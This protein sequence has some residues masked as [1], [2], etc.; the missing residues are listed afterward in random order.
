[1]ELLHIP[2]AWPLYTNTF[3][4]FSGDGRAAVVDP[5]PT[6][7]VYEKALAEHGARLTDICSP[8]AITTMSLRSRR[9]AAAPGPRSAWTPPTP[10]GT[11]LYPLTPDLIDEP[12]PAADGMVEAAGLSFRLWHTP[13][14]T[15]G[16]VC[17][18]TDGCLFCGDTLFAGSCGRMDLPGGSVA[19]MQK[20]LAFIAALPLRTRQRF[21]PGTSAFPPLARSAAKTLPD[22]GSLVKMFYLKLQGGAQC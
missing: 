5:A 1:M 9:C 13:G 20:S 11:E 22:G 16:G 6:P 18:Y 8:T 7:A 19:E 10:L 12:W 14:H 2:G 3:L 15:K 21:C 4:L 17:L